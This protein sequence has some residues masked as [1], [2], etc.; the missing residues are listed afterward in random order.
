MALL[1]ALQALLGVTPCLYLALLQPATATP[2]LGATAPEQLQGM[3]QRAAATLFTAHSERGPAF[4]A[5]AAAIDHPHR[6][7]GDAVKAKAAPRRRATSLTVASFNIRYSNDANYDSARAPLQRL[8]RALTGQQQ[9]YED[10]AL[11]PAPSSAS[12]AGANKRRTQ[13]SPSLRHKYWGERSWFLRG[14]RIADTVL[15]HDWDLFAMQ[16]VLDAQYSNLRQWLGDDYATVGVGRDDG[17]RAGEAVPLWWKRDVLELVG[18]SEGGVGRHGVEH[19]WLS[20]T[21]ERAG[22]VGWDAGLTRMCTHVSLRILETGEVVHVFSTHYDDR[23]VVARVESSRL[24]L[25]RAKKAARRTQRW[26]RA[27]GLDEAEEPLMVLLG[28]LNSP[29]SEASWTTLVAGHYGVPHRHSTEADVEDSPTFLD[30]ALSVPTRHRSP[31]LDANESHHGAQLASGAVAP[32]PFS[33]NIS[34]ADVG[35]LSLPY[36]P[37]RTFTGFEPSPR[38]AEEDRL[39]FIMLLDNGAVVDQTRRDAVFPPSSEV[40]AQQEQRQHR[41]QRQQEGKWKVKSYGVV[42]SWSEGDAGFLISDHRPVV[43]RIEKR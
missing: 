22:S 20:P 1:R 31:Y 29:R 32:A 34:S 8:K 24:I 14:P 27:N 12:D 39:D 9:L 11:H 30:V 19:F 26:M 33:T 38:S 25:E 13:R 37:L 40:E 17:R 36:G 3:L 2:F 28:D 35:H 41:E 42:P 23:G 15:F 4:A 21:P 10:P 5:A 7:G 6:D 18:E 43:A 16:E